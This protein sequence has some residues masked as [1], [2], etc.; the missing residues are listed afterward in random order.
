LRKNDEHWDA[1]KAVTADIVNRQQNERKRSCGGRSQP[2]LF[3]KERSVV[4]GASSTG[5][6]EDK[7]MVLSI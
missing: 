2:Y 4:M 1:D 7:V 5:I 6:V 3:E